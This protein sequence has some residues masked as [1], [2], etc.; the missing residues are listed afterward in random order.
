M[1]DLISTNRDAIA[2]LCR[3]FGIRKLEVF[4]S[5]STGAF[6]PDRSDLDFIADLGGY[7][8]GVAKRYLRFARA[9]EALLE[10]PVEIITDEQIVN[11]YFRQSVEEQRVTVYWP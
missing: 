4:G 3:E 6:D 8:R 1:I 5:A 11:P 10:R 2:D 7:E 9:L